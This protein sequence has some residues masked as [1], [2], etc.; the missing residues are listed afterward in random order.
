M[1]LGDH[2][3]IRSLQ[4]EE[5]PVGEVSYVGADKLIH[6]K[7]LHTLS[8]YPILSATMLQVGIGTSISPTMWRPILEQLVRDGK[9]TRTVYQDETPGGRS[10]TYTRFQLAATKK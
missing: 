8:I 6:D 4:E 3:S 9:I 10:Q 1:A 7:I 2:P 5:G